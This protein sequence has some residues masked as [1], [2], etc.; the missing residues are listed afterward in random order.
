MEV[1]KSGWGKL[2]YC[3]GKSNTN[4]AWSSLLNIDE[5]SLQRAVFKRAA[6]LLIYHSQMQRFILLHL[7]FLSG[8]AP[9]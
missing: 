7:M 5:L 8:G 6:K 1:A 3:R 9:K 2:R 4:N